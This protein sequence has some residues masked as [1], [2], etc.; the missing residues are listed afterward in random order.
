MENEKFYNYLI[1]ES[2]RIYHERLAII[3]LDMANN[4]TDPMWKKRYTARRYAQI[5]L[6][7]KYTAMA[8]KAKE[9][10]HG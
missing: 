3:F 7:R 1:C 5:R 2:K 10:S 8:H 9:K 6:V 4:T